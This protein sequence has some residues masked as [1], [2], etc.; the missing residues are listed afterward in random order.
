MMTPSPRVVSREL[1]TRE[2]FTPATTLNL[3]A[4]S[5]LQ[6]QI[7]DWFSHG[8]SVKDD[9]WMIPLAENDTWPQPDMK[10]LRVMPDPTRTERGRGK[11]G[12]ACEHRDALVGWVAVVW[13]QC[14]VPGQCADS[15]WMGR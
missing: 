4:A 14:G 15:A 5:W 1:M 11:A 9:P 6:F 12:D 7:R 2:S 3:L 10:V 13:K 8:Q